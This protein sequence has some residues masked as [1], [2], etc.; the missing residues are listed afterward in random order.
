MTQAAQQYRLGKTAARPGAVRLKLSNYL[1]ASALPTPPATFGH[2]NL[3]GATAWGMLGNDTV[4]DCVLAGGGHE[5]MLWNRE[6]DKTV[7]FTAANSI[8]DYSAITGYNPDDPAT[9]KGTDMEVAAKY[10]RKTGLLDGDSKRHKVAAYVD[11][12]VADLNE[13]L[14]AAYLFGAVGIGIQFPKSAMDQFNAGQPWDVVAGAEIEGGHYVPFVGRDPDF[15]Y[16]VTWGRIQPMT[17]AFFE[18]YNDESIA[19]LSHEMLSGGKSLEGFNVSQ[20]K[21]DLAQVTA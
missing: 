16:V 4:G 8:L 11:V 10:R 6:A 18:K 20:L 12:Q 9:D 15:L 19:Y 5:T 3:I 13:H 1:D 21:T 17:T 14:I 7:P 2:E